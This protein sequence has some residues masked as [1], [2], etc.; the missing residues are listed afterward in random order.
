MKKTIATLLTATLTLSLLAGCG[1]NGEETTTPAAD[2]TPSA[3]TQTEKTV[4]K[5]GASPTP[6]AV[7]LEVVKDALA[8]ENI[9]LQ[10]VEFDDYI[11]PNTALEEGEL[12]A[13][14]F[15]HITYLNSFNIEHGTHLSSVG[16]IHYEPIGI[17]AGKTASLADLPDGATIAV[18]DDTTN[19]TRALLLLEQEGLITLKER[20]D[21]NATKDD[22]ADNPHNYQIQELRADTITSCLPDVDVA[23]INGNY[24]IDAGL[25]VSEALAIE[26]A[27]GEAT[28]AYGNIIAVKEGNEDNAAVQALVKALQSQ[29]VKTFVKNTYDGAVVTVF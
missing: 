15:Q 9:D 8:E 3:Q 24:A 21:I 18:P 13:N 19:E 12:D 2:P 7:I 16:V 26:S 1:G 25:K 6:H 28:Q 10:I 22:I 20:A 17:Y 23:V 27:E 5:V 4:L 14:Y 29:E 11:I